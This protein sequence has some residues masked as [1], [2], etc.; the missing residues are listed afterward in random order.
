MKT[1]CFKSYKNFI[2]GK[3][4]EIKHDIQLPYN[5]LAYIKSYLLKK[6]SSMDKKYYG[7]HH[8]TYFGNYLPADHPYL[9]MTKDQ[10]L[11]KFLPYIKRI[12]QNIPLK[13]LDSFL[14][15][16]PFAQPVHELRYSS[17]APKL[18]TPIPNV[19]LTNMDSIVPWDRGTNYAVELGI[20]AAEKI[21]TQ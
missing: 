16:G 7:G 17:R 1:L 20:H 9:S 18:E 2:A 3:W 10:L 14:F 11:K 21:L 12:N 4:Y 8:L 15:I 5:K 13:I 19:Y 6:I